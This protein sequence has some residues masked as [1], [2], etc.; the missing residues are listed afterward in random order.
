MCGELSASGS[1][2]GGCQVDQKRADGCPRWTALALCLLRSVLGRGREPSRQARRARFG[3][4]SLKGGGFEK[5]LTVLLG[6]PP[7]SD[8]IRRPRSGMPVGTQGRAD[9]LARYSA[10][11]PKWG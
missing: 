6:I 5:G 9:G 11:F 10:G 8:L 1:C 4:G 3:D 7:F 2:P